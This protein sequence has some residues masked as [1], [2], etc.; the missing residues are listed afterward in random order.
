MGG[1]GR[2]GPALLIVAHGAR[3]SSANRQ[4]L[5]LARRIRK[6]RPKWLVRAAFLQF[7]GPTIA[8]VFAILAR[9]GATRVMVHP[10]FLFAGRHAARDLPAQLAAAAELH[11]QLRWRLTPSLGQHPR[12]A[13]MVLECARPK[14]TFGRRARGS[15][16]ARSRARRSS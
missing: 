8:E 15:A 2:A 4:V 6:L 13:R 12:L 7:V 14:R 11:P 9:L 1:S 5:E 3:R 10:L 16:S